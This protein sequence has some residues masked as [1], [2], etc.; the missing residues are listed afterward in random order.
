MKLEH[1]EQLINAYHTFLGMMS[2][3]HEVGFDFFEGK[4]RMTVPVDLMIDMA[5]KSHYTE[6]GVDLIY[7]FIFENDFGNNEM[8]IFDNDQEV[9]MD[10]IT[11]LHQYIEKN[12]RA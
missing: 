12:Y 9:A 5:I 3:L 11:D 2:D 10:T 6:K 7:W 4:W 8:K 1:F